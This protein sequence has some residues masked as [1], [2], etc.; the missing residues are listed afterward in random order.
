MVRDVRTSITVPLSQGSTKPETNC[1]LIF[2]QFSI[3][4]GARKRPGRGDKGCPDVMT[5]TAHKHLS[6]RFDVRR[7]SRVTGLGWCRWM[8]R[9]PVLS[10]RYILSMPFSSVYKVINMHTRLWYL[11]TIRLATWY[12]RPEH[13]ALS[14]PIGLSWIL[15]DFTSLGYCVIEN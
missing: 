8:F 12:N 7:V 3:Q 11:H 1:S 13:G 10:C 6:A 2:Q 9:W 15:Q 14:M 4:S 5:R